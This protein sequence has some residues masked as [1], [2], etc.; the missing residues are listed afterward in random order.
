[1]DVSGR[2]LRIWMPAIH[3]GMTKYAFSFSAGER[4]IM[5]H[6]VEIPEIAGVSYF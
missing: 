3:A 6:F 2:I 5:N 4:R 1:M